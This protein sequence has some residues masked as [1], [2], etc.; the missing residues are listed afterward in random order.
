[1]R[2]IL[3]FVAIC[4]SLSLNAQKKLVPA[5][6][7]PLTG[8]QLP[9][10]TLLDKRLI[11]TGSA[12][13]LLDDEIKK[14]GAKIA[15]AEVY[16][17]TEQMLKNC[18][19]DSLKKTLT[20]KGW[21]II[22]YE[23]S[24]EYTWLVKGSVYVLAYL[25]INPASPD[26]YFGKV[27]GT[28]S[29]KKVTSNTVSPAPVVTQPV[30][31]NQTTIKSEPLIADEAA[32]TLI[33]TWLMTS[34]INTYTTGTLTYAYTKKQFTINKDGS[35]VFYSKTYDISMTDIILRKENGKYSVSGNKLTLNPTSST[36]ET[37]SKLDG[38]DKW[39]Q[40]LT[41]NPRPLEKTTYLFTRHYFEG[42]GEW[43]LVLQPENKKQTE[44]EGIFSSNSAFPNSYLYSIPPNDSYLIALPS[45]K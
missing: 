26:L 40:R 42:I 14:S 23:N 24:K 39:G 15:Y 1:M 19:M 35:Y 31:N 20:R 25:S 43:N 7:S 11:S 6:S 22:P 2:N 37:W 41:S 34:S 16:K 45:G 9:A 33:G 12:A 38:A 8:I 5:T 13:L 28:P 27:D 17:L 4:F 36:I 44:R 32:S 3:L 30:E 29:F 21:E 18:T 10:G